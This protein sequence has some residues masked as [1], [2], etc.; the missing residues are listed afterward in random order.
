MTPNF[1]TSKVSLHWTPFLPLI[2][3]SIQAQNQ[4][5]ILGLAFELRGKKWKTA[6]CSVDRNESAN[7]HR[8]RGGASIASSP[9]PVDPHTDIEISRLILRAHLSL[10]I[11]SLVKYVKD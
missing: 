6:Y 7:F 5:V 1:Q 9:A 8:T 3:D 11:N 10:T 2:V 4:E